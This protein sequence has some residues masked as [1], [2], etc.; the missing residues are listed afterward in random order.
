MSEKVVDLEGKARYL[1]KLGTL[2]V[3]DPYTIVVKC[4]KR[5]EAALAAH[6]SLTMDDIYNYLVNARSYITA[7]QFRAF[8]SLQ[9]YKHVV[10]GYVG[11]FGIYPVNKDVVIMM[12]KVS[13]ALLLSK[14]SF[15]YLMCP[16]LFSGFSFSVLK[17]S[18]CKSMDCM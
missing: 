17:S 8:K 2:G 10:E 4:W 12:A 1:E 13:F 11:S 16:L 14:L 5:S 7:A 18:T 15:V 6:P 9:S 3:Q